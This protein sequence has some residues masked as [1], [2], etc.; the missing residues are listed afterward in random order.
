[1]AGE[2]SQPQARPDEKKALLCSA[3][4]VYEP[5]RWAVT[6]FGVSSTLG[7]LKMFELRVV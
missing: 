4:F 7:K 5:P 1:M 2:L 3:F 6:F